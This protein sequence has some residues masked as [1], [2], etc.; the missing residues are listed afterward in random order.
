MAAGMKVYVVP[1]HGEP[2]RIGRR[3]SITS[4][5]CRCL[6]G[7]RL[8]SSFE[9]FLSMQSSMPPFDTY[10]RSESLLLFW[11]PSAASPQPYVAATENKSRVLPVGGIGGCG[12]AAPLRS[13]SKQRSTCGAIRGIAS[14]ATVCQA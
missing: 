6:S 4:S 11:Y 10:L 14:K 7:L 1:L 2:E 12:K 8:R 5:L 9:S 13:A 3:S